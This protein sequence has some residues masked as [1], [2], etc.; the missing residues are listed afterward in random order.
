MSALL[1]LAIAL[2][3]IG[4]ASYLAA[5]QGL[6]PDEETPVQPP[7]R[8]LEWVFVDT[9]LDKIRRRAKEQ[10]KAIKFRTKRKQRKA[11]QIERKAAEIVIAQPE[12]AESHLHALMWQWAEQKPE[13]AQGID[14]IQE[15]F[16]AQV[17][18]IIARIKK[19][20]EDEED[21]EE[22]IL[23]MLIF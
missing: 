11:R 10:R 19:Q 15:L 21:D 16:A 9:F 13:Q 14:P 23:A 18:S 20:I 22:S 3:G 7:L 17:A 4:F 6:A 12:N 5:V 1:P 2:Q 8:E